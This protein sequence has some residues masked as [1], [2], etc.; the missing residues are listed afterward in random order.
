MR[1]IGFVSDPTII[2]DRPKTPHWHS[3]SPN[4]RAL[5][6]RTDLKIIIKWTIDSFHPVTLSL[7]TNKS[8]EQPTRQDD[9]KHK[10]DKTMMNDT[11]R[12]FL[13]DMIQ[14]HREDAS[15]A[16]TVC[17]VDDNHWSRPSTQLQTVPSSATKN[18]RLQRSSRW[19]AVASVKS[20]DEVMRMPHRR[21]E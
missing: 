21:P 15:Q 6:G 5:L 14:S 4:G 8:N 7:P 17:L 1:E 10:N 18:K 16:M 11:L 2:R 9:D 12:S 13:M 3:D 19:D 20:R